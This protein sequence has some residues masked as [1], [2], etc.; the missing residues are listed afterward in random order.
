M[1]TVCA[2]D[3]K[4][5]ISWQQ[6]QSEDKDLVYKPYKQNHPSCPQMQLLSGPLSHSTGGSELFGAQSKQEVEERI[7]ICTESAG[8]FKLL[9]LLNEMQNCFKVKKI[10]F[11]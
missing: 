11:W 4:C 5:D 3:K 2:S 1:I 9:V 6:F 7:E 10:I 8:I